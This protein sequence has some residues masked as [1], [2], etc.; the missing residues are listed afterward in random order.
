MGIR[1]QGSWLVVW[2]ALAVMCVG[3]CGSDITPENP[4]GT[5][6]GPSQAGPTTGGQSV[7]QPGSGGSETTAGQ[8]TAQ[9]APERTV[10]PVKLTDAVRQTCLVQVGQVL[11][12]RPDELAQLQ[13]IHGAAA[14]A[15]EVSFGQK[16]TVVCFWQLGTSQRSRLAALDMLEFLDKDIARE[17]A[18]QGLAVV[19]V[20]VGDSAGLGDLDP[21]GEIRVP[22]LVDLQGELF[23]RMAVGTEHMP[24]IYLL[25]GQGR[26]LW[27]DVEY[28][29]ATRRYL[30]EAIEAT[31]G[32]ST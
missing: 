1:Q 15:S 9:E 6:P 28:S 4:P 10:P 12:V 3:G 20:H 27:F 13:D 29:S 8:G 26:V 25:D 5:S 7:Q 21:T 23:A 16:L 18:G 11:P 19:C 24:R 31:L 2:M 14:A 30:R 22:C 17:F 32:P